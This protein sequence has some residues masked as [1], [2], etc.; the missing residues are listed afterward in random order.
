ML[1]LS[2][3]F[4]TSNFPSN[5]SNGL[6]YLLL[7]LTF[8][9]GKFC[10]NFDTKLFLWNEVFCLWNISIFDIEFNINVFFPLLCLIQCFFHFRVIFFLF[11]M[12]F[13]DVFNHPIQFNYLSHFYQLTTIVANI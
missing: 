8:F 9:P 10:F 3:V 11:L 4:P 12:I 7:F 5:V 6:S 2:A 13:V 1:P